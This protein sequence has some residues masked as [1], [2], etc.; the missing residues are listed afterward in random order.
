MAKLFAAEAAET[1]C[2]DEIQIHGGYGCLADFTAERL[3]R[4]VRA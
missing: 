1:I 2:S 4:D 3:N